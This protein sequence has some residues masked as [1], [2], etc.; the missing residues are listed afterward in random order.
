M[1]EI[2]LTDNRG[3]DAVVSAESV[4]IAHEYRWMD[5]DDMQAG[6]RKILRATVQNDIDRLTEDAGGL[7]ELAEALVEDDPELDVESLGRFLSETSRAYLDPDG[8]IVH[9][10][11]RWQ[12]IHTPEGEEKDRRPL[13]TEDPNVAGEV[14]LQWTGKLMKKDEA[15]RK[16]VFSGKMQ[17]HHINGLTYD[18]LFQMAKE[19]HDS[20]SLMLLGGGPKGTKPLV[21]RRGGLS[22]RGFLEG[23]VEGERYAL[24]LHLSNM[25]L[26]RPAEA[27]VEKEGGETKEKAKTKSAA[28]KK[29]SGSKKAP[30]KKSTAA[31][32]RTSKKAAAKKKKTE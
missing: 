3:R 10:L 28:A 27:P 2:N 18:F 29:K 1:A 15:C 6:S 23:R 16:F 32:K 4:T 5:E 31:K 30:K 8:E 21:F 26:R 19:L 20:K 24:I 14:P 13:V 12:V 9:H 22:Y 11:S 17:I 25:E 7:E